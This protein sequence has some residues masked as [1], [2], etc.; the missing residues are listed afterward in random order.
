MCVGVEQRVV[1][2]DPQCYVPN[3]CFSRLDFLEGL[4]V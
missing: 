1:A 4:E 3:F 2:A